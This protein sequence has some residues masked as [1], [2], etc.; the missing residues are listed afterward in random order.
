MRRTDD[1]KNIIILMLDTAR[2]DDVYDD[3]A[4]HTLNYLTRNGTNYVH[5]ISPGAWTATSHASLF[6]NNLVSNIRQ[7]SK[8]FFGRNSIDLWFANIKFLNDNQETLASKL[9]RHGYYSTLFSNNP[10]LTSF[11]NLALGFN[12]VYDLWLYT[13]T[14]YVSGFAEKL[15]FLAKKAPENKEKIYKLVNAISRLIPSRLLDRAYINSRKRLYET[16]AKFDGSSKLDKGA[17]DINRVLNRYLAEDYSYLPQFIFVNYMEP[18]EH[19]P[20]RSPIPTPDKWLH[21]SGVSRLSESDLEKLHDGYKRRLRYL[22]GAVGKTIAIMKKHGLLDN[23]VLVVTSDH[24]QFFGEHGMLYHSL[25]PYEEQTHVPLL[26]VNFENGRLIKTK[27]VVDN[28]VNITSLYDSVLGIASGKD[29]MLNGNLKTPR[30][31]FSEHTGLM[32]GSDEMLLK[33]LKSRSTYASR[34]YAAKENYNMP[35]TAIYHNNLKMI[36]YFGRKQDELYDLAEDKREEEN[37]IQSSRFEAHAMLNGY[38][39]VKKNN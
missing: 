2:A 29:A 27:E 9:S 38:A 1:K 21:L 30:H 6:T 11:T 16:V 39:A 37:L 28:T 24:G 8:N 33:L 36:H 19:Y 18:H 35:A 13:N 7:V 26:A 5:A 10:F 25:F 34:I 14:K 22:D 4:L 12:K 23:A 32:D 15:L 20:V 3:H 17:S 31:V